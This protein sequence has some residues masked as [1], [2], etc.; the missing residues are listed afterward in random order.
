MYTCTFVY[1]CTCTCVHVYLSPECVVRVIQTV[2]DNHLMILGILWIDLY[3]YN[4]CTV[5]I[6]VH[7]CTCIHACTFVHVKVHV[8]CTCMYMYMHM[9][10]FQCCTCTSEASPVMPRYLQLLL[11]D[12][13]NLE[14]YLAVLETTELLG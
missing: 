5:Y 7:V 3:W 8:Q 11:V 1:T 10:T 13:T 4:T 12:V 6:H 2:Y 9:R 14:R